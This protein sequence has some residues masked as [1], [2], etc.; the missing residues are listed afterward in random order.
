MIQLLNSA[1]GGPRNVVID[2]SIALVKN[3]YKVD[4]LTYDKEK[5]SYY[6]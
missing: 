6:E 4:I 3:K 2:S 5:S 1:Y